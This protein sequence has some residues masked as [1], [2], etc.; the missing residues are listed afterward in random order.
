MEKLHLI[1]NAHLDPVWLW[2]WKEGAAEAVSTF[3]IAADFCEKY[4]GFVFNH[5]EALL[6]E[7]VEEY[8]PELFE[9]IKKLVKDGKWKIMGGWYLQPD[10]TML[11]GESFLS[12]IELGRKYF[13]EKNQ[14]SQKMKIRILLVQKK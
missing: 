9:R 8:E 13:R 11:S 1:C 2:Q 4:D 10:C 5:N 7:W 14:T 6:Y 12:Q 3:R